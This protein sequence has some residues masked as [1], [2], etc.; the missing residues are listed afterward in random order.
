MCYGFLYAQ[1]QNGKLFNITIGE[2]TI[3]K[4]GEVALYP[5]SKSSSTCP[6]ST[7]QPNSTSSPH[8][9]SSYT[10]TL[11]LTTS[12]IDIDSNNIVSSK[13]ITSTFVSA[14]SLLGTDSSTSTPP[15]YNCPMN[16]QQT[17]PWVHVVYCV[18]IVIIILISVI[19]FL[20]IFIYQQK[21]RGHYTFHGTSDT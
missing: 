1:Q 14:T 12:T 2:Y 11:A 13:I 7:I 5:A 10:T 6:I 16:I 19:V 8:G 21:N 20:L 9:T 18:I 15:A 17:E 4:E 3:S